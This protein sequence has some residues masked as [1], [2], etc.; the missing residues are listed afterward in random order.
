AER[1]HRDAVAEAER[2]R[3]RL[4]D[5]RNQARTAAAEPAA[6]QRS[7]DTAAEQAHDAKEEAEQ[8]AAQGEHER[9]LTQ[10]SFPT[11][12]SQLEFEVL[13]PRTGLV[14]ALTGLTG[15]DRARVEEQVSALGDDEL[16]AAIR[17][18]RIR[19]GDVDVTVRPE[20]HRPA[21]TRTAPPHQQPSSTSSDAATEQTVPLAEATSTSVPIRIP[22]SFVSPLDLV[23]TVV[24]PMVYV[25]GTVKTA[26]RY[27]SSVTFSGSTSTSRS[28]VPATMSLE[29]S[30]P[31]GPRATASLDA[32]L[33]LPEITRGEAVAGTLPDGDF[34]DVKALPA[35][36]P[37]AFEDVLGTSRE[38]AAGLADH[39]LAPTT[40]PHTTTVDGGPVTFLPLT[41]AQVS[42]VGTTRVDSSSAVSHTRGA[43]TTRG[44]DA[45]VGLG[46]YGGGKAHYVGGFLDFS[47]GL[48]DGG[49]LST[50]DS[51]TQ[52]SGEH[53]LVY[54]VSRDMRVGT[55]TTEPGEDAPQSTVRTLVQVPVWRARELGLPLPP[56]L[57]GE[58]AREATGQTYLFGRDDIKFVDRDKVTE[59]ITSR[60][61]D[62]DSGLSANGRAAIEAQ[63][64]TPD[65][66]KHTLHNA[67]HGGAR[68]VWT[69]GGRTHFVDV[70]AIPAPPDRTE[71]SGQQDTTTEVKHTEKFQRS[72]G[73]SRTA[74]IGAGGAF[75]PKGTDSPDPNPPKATPEDGLPNPYQG[76]PTQSTAGPRVALSATYDKGLSTKSGYSGKDGRSAKYSGDMRDY[77]G[78]LDLVVVHGSTKDP[79]WAQRFF[80]GGK[81]SQSADARYTGPSRT[82]LDR[83]LA[84]DGPTDQHVHRGR[85]D[86]AIRVATPADKL[87]WA[88]RPLPPSGTRPGT[89]L[90]APPPLPST[91]VLGPEHFGEFATVEHVTTSPNSTEALDLAL[92]KRIEPVGGGAVRTPPKGSGFWS[93]WAQKTFTERRVD[94]D[95]VEH[96]TEYVYKSSEL[97]RPG[98]TSAEAVREFQGRVGSLGTASQGLSGLSNS[99][100]GMM[101]EGRLTDFTGTLHG[102]ATYHSPRLV[103]VRAESTLKRNQAG[104]QTTSTTSSWGA[105]VDAEVNANAIPRQDGRTGAMVSGVLGGGAKHGRS[106]AAELTTGGTQDFEYTGPTALVSVDVRYR[107]WADM[108][109]RNAVHTG[110]FDPVEVTVDEPGGAVVEVPVQQAIDMFTALGLDV[111][112]E[113]SA[114][115]PTPKPG[116]DD[117]AHTLAPGPGEYAS[118]SDTAVRDA[119]LAGDDPM[120]PVRQRLTELGVTDAAQQ[121]QVTDQVDALLNSPTGRLWLPD[122]LAGQQGLISVPLSGPLFEDV[123]DVRVREVFDGDRATTQTD[124]VNPD[125]VT[126]SAYV[127]TSEQHKSTTAWS[128]NASLNA[129]VRYAETPPV[130]P[131]R[132]GPDGEVQQS[133]PEPG[134][135]GGGFT[136]QLFGGAKSSKTERV[137]DGSG[138]T[139]TTTRVDTDKVGSGTRPVRYELDITRRRAPM[140]ALDTT[141]LGV[142]KH[143][144]DLDKG[145][146]AAPVRLDGEV[147]L[148]SPSSK[149]SPPLAKPPRPPEFELVDAP[150]DQRP[151]FSPEDAVR[152]EAIGQ[153][154]AKAVRDAVYAQLSTRMPPPGQTM[155]GEE[156]AASAQR[157]SEFTRPGSS[158]EHVVHSTAKGTS[159]HHAANALFTG[160]G[161]QA[162]S[163]LGTKHPLYDSL[164]DLQLTG[165]LRPQDLT[166]VA[167]LPEG[168][169]MSLTR[170]VE[171]STP[172]GTTTTV[173]TGLSAGASGYGA[174]THQAAGPSPTSVI[175]APPASTTVSDERTTSESSKAGETSGVKHEGRSYLFRA[176]SAEIYSR[177]HVHGSNWTHKPLGAIKS[178]F[179]EHGHPQD[180]TVKITSHDDVHVRVWESTALDKG[181][182]TL[183]D[184]WRHAGRLPADQRSYA[185]SGDPRGATIHPAGRPV[186][187]AGQPAPGAPRGRTLHV[188]PGVSLSDVTAFVGTLPSDMRPSAYTVAPGQGFT[189]ADVQDAVAG[190]PEPGTESTTPPGGSSTVE[191]EAAGTTAAEPPAPTEEQARPA[192]EGSSDTAVEQAERGTERPGPARSVPHTDAVGAPSL[193]SGPDLAAVVPPGTRFA[194]PASFVGLINDGWSPGLA[195]VHAALA[196]HETYHGRPQVAHGTAGDA[197]S[198]MVGASQAVGA[199]PVAVGRGEDGLAEVVR[200][201][202]RAGHGADAL[203]FSFGTDGQA[204]AWNVVN[205]GGTVSLVDAHFGTVVPA[206][207]E[208]FHGLGE[209]FAIPLDAEG[210]FVPDEH[211]PPP[212]PGTVSYE[213]ARLL[214]DLMAV[215]TFEHP[216][217]GTVTMPSAHPEDGCYIRAH[218]WAAKLRA[219]GFDVR[220][221]FM[222]RGGDVLSTL[223]H[224]AYGATADHPRLVTWGYHVAP[225][226]SVDLGNGLPPVEMVFDP[227]MSYDFSGAVDA[228]GAGLFRG[229]VPVREWVRAAGIHGGFPEADLYE[230][231][232][233]HEGEGP[234]APGEVR[235]RITDAHVVG[236]PWDVPAPGSFQQADLVVESFLDTAY[237]HSVE[238]AHRAEFTEWHESLPPHARQR[239]NALDAQFGGAALREF[240][241][242]F[243]TMGPADR[244]ALAGRLAD[245]GSSTSDLLPPWNNRV[246][247]ARV[248]LAGLSEDD[249][250]QAR[251]VA[252]TLAETYH[253]G[254]PQDLGDQV[255]DVLAHH[256]AEDGYPAAQALAASLALTQPTDAIGAA[257]QDTAEPAGPT[258]DP[259]TVEDPPRGP[260][261]RSREE[262]ESDEGPA[263]HYEP[264]HARPVPERLVPPAPGDTDA[265]LAAVPPGTRFADPASFVGLVNGTRSEQGRDVNCVDAALA[266]HETYHGRPRVAGSA[267]DGV[268]RGAGTAAAE[269]LGYAPEMFSR[270]PAGL[271][272]VIDRVT[273]AGHGADALVIG[274]RRGGGGHAWNVVNHGGT[275]SIV[276]AQAGTVRPAG[277]DGFGWLDRVYAIPVDAEGRYVDDTA[278]APRAPADPADAYARAEHER[279]QRAHEVRRAAA[280]GE[281]I[282]VPGTTGRLVPSLGGLRLVGAA[283]TAELAADLASLS[284][285]D[286]IALVVGADAQ[287]DERDREPPASLEQL[288]FPPRGRPEPVDE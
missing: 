30:V 213:Q 39:L 272:E 229:F 103:D 275:V 10:L 243:R 191:T 168:T 251:A 42:Y 139:K 267:P 89:Y 20:L 63:F 254:L 121:R 285:R 14:D 131:G 109:L 236:P 253:A 128:V 12:D 138:G 93:T 157:P 108:A 172:A 5:L 177:V 288:R 280:A 41:D 250:A 16:L 9:G 276:D 215:D 277:T 167:A 265:L 84:G 256:A 64:R 212:Q 268:P 126:R 205:H 186:P 79:N 203:V 258:A 97:T 87:D 2:L 161:Y 65:I 129:G 165:N 76:G 55:G 169:S 231:R 233:W 278:P 80:L 153:D 245:P 105:A 286:V 240:H 192:T 155:T 257:P 34:R 220:K 247:T 164:F 249:S 274:F 195:P 269:G 185:V 21:D 68:A 207:P 91:T 238:V 255:V 78:A 111:P 146:G 13:G 32:G 279:A 228:P 56:H 37:Q 209:V 59:F 211:A 162:G 36:V 196:F 134:A 22:L 130:P 141:A 204:S 176:D 85:V 102:E 124:A 52:S 174:D 166:F 18:G 237:Q 136:P 208:S 88:S 248:Q 8:A 242:W 252:T 230:P 194:D 74:R 217:H 206:S 100:G 232:P 62:T 27:D 4:D 46:L 197:R 178:A 188:A 38:A 152:V 118:Y 180:S 127:S 107:Y 99:T 144:L 184:V 33:R 137:L 57:Q 283:V 125:K 160:G 224:N 95:G 15:M 150:P 112:P 210:R 122:V 113:L 24:R 26:H 199:A 198:T 123:V 120:A 77:R 145:V 226:L 73:S 225:V 201:V 163:V 154:T 270:G 28:H 86:D 114:L 71:P 281:E 53:H 143:L 104:D 227:A 82:D 98:T 261:K 106:H 35:T 132:P 156:V 81:L 142:P 31:G 149:A 284:Q 287:D 200:R 133:P 44:S 83:V 54:E 135:A 158:S 140:P 40:T 273:R 19:V 159:L 67:M 190:L 43:T 218:L 266:F 171:S 11:H 264:A 75:L 221:V 7:A 23:G 110:R 60:V 101:R 222:S 151:G 214:Y 179:R 69:E 45:N 271:A 216:Q 96:T 70:H 51:V 181:L 94:A 3:A 262:F 219:L 25:G 234:I 1:R 241:D 92:A 282:P 48:T 90:G 49:A 193:V 72:Y 50:D 182:L 17:D 58:S 202:E 47:S 235:I 61:R 175:V 263:T 170:E 244:A 148:V 187:P 66:A 116:V 115:R 259:S 223:S 239:F 29:L 117:P 173:T 246:A 183:H 147:D 6:A 189:A 119:R 260:R